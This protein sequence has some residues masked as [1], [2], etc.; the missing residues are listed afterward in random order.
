MKNE[1]TKEM[2][3]EGK[4]IESPEA[5]SKEA[6]N[7]EEALKAEAEKVMKDLKLKKIYHFGGYWFRD[8]ECA[9][10]M[11]RQMKST[12]NIKIFEM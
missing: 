4:V 7:A 11:K 10:Q 5:E 1:N 8:S 9:K 12:D 6:K 2:T 3:D